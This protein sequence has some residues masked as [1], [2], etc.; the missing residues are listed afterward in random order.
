MGVILE[1][2]IKNRGGLLLI[3]QARPDMLEKGKKREYKG[4]RPRKKSKR[5]RPSSKSHTILK[6]ILAFKKL[7]LIAP[8]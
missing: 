5:R 7:T 1:I 2:A 6:D 4:K 8:S 3:P